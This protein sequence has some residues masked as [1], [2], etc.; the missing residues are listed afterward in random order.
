MLD[1]EDW[2]EAMHDEL[3][4]FMHNQVWELVPRPTEEHNVIGTK[5]IFKNK[6]DVNG[7]V[8]QNKARLVAQG[9]SQVEGIDYCRGYIPWR[10]PAG[11]ITRPDLATH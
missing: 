10:N 3:N 7:V 2:L 8:V 6:Q 9:Y 1:D 4:N 11:S 5:W